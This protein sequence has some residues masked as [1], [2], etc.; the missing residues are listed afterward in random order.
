MFKRMIA[1]ASFAIIPTLGA[2]DE[3]PTEIVEATPEAPSFSVIGAEPLVGSIVLN[4]GEASEPFTGTC[5]LAGRVT[6]N[7]TLVRNPT[8]GGLLTCRWTP[9]PTT[10]VFDRAFRAD[11]FNCFLNFFGSTTTR[12][13]QIVIARTGNVATL[14]CKFREVGA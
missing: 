8:G 5:Q 14:T 11:G 4:R 2:C 13:S 9:W 3:T 1:L 10:T 12:N 6:T 7:V